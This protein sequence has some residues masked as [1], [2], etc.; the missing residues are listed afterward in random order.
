[1][2]IVIL[3]NYVSKALAILEQNGYEAFVVG[4]AVRDFLLNV[5]PNDYDIS[6]SATPEEVKAA[7]KNYYTFDSGIIHGT[8]TVFLDHRQLEIT[9]YRV[10][11]D[12]GDFR[13]PDQ[14][15]FVKNL[16][17]DLNR[18]DFTINALC[19]NKT[20]IDQVGGVED[21]NN[22]LI[23]AIG[24]PVLRFTED[25][26]RIVRALRFASALGFSIEAKTALAL[27]Q[28]SPL[29]HKV[30]ME[31]I[32]AELNKM[33]LGKLATTV[34]E[35]YWDV[36]TVIISPLVKLDAQAVIMRMDRTKGLQAKLAALL[37]G[38]G[39]ETA[40][41]ILKKMKYSNQ[42]I[43][44]IIRLIDGEKVDLFGDD[45]ALIRLLGS[46]EFSEL[47]DLIEFR[48]SDPKNADKIE[49]Y[50]IV[51]KRVQHLNS[52]RHC[53]RVKDL[54]INGTDLLKIGFSEGIGI[55][56]V[57]N[58]LLEEVIT[59]KTENKREDLL[60]RAQSLFEEKK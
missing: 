24:D 22:Q 36:M 3:P 51:L 50:Q 17:E 25:P 42:D 2:I 58:G 5:S 52:I 53:F 49:Q 12:Y 28:L 15:T 18:R 39:A 16:T 45:V 27:R 37:L 60:A 1:L 48:M 7:F 29:L 14:T 56:Q 46:Y 44:G 35:E 4:G 57:L 21:L 59:D 13:H 26:L 9:T 40:A 8:I 19:F 32:T 6:T 43:K 34:L 30:S 55:N 11:G 47:T 31:R 41:Q 38:L 23:R 54:E 33:L 10:D 20:L